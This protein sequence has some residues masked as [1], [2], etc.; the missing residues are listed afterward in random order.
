MMLTL[1]ETTL[2]YH[3]RRTQPGASNK[4]TAGI[5]KNWRKAVEIEP[6]AG[7]K[8]LKSSGVSSVRSAS[9]TLRNLTTTDTTSSKAVIA[10]FEDKEAEERDNDACG[11]LADEFELDGPEG[12]SAKLSP[13][14]GKKRVTSDVSFLLYYL[15]RLH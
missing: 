2:F 11:G 12:K 6:A 13:F 9:T 5:I 10:A 3:Y 4:N 15:H 1:D 8:S 14:K 7:V